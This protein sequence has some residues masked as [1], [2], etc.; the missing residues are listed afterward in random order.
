MTRKTLSVVVVGH[1]DH[2]KSTLIGRL[3]HDTGSLRADQVQAVKES[4]ARRGGHFEWAHLLDAFQAER[5]SAVTIDT[6]QAIL[7]MKGRDYYLID[8]P[9][10]REFL[11]SMVSGA[12]RADAAILVVDAA[13]GLCE[14]TMRHAYLLKLIGV[15][16]IIVA[17]TKMDAI[18]FD[19]TGF[20]SVAKNLTDYLAGLDLFASHVIPVSATDGI[21]VMHKGNAPGWYQGKTVMEAL[22]LLEGTAETDTAP[23]CFSVQD[24]Y[25]FDKKRVIA[26]RV[27]TGALNTGDAV[28]IL[29]SG[30]KTRIASIE[31]WPQPQ[32]SPAQS[33]QSIGLTLEDPVFI[34]RGYVLCNDVTILKVCNTISAHVVWLANDPLTSGDSCIIRIGS[35][36]FSAR[37]QSIDALIDLQNSTARNNADRISKND[38]ARVSLRVRGKAII[39]SHKN[40]AR[41]II[42]KDNI[43]CGAGM[44][45]VSACSAIG[46]AA[47]PKSHNIQSVSHT[48]TL[49]M[50]AARAG[51]AGGIFWLTGLPGAG[52]STLA[53]AVEQVLFER[54]INAYVLDGDNLRHGLNKDL[55]FSQEDRHENIRRAGEVA[56]LQ[57]D[58]GLVVLASFISPYQADRAAAR[59]A[60]PHLF[61]EIFIRADLATCEARDPK[62]HYKK[63]RTG[64]IADFTGI[65]AP[66]EVPSD[67]DLVI[68][69]QKCGIDQCVA[70][71]VDY[72][73]AQACLTPHHDK[74]FRS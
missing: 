71:I 54:R 69:T 35:Q 70:Q 46:Q 18:G 51:H 12:T 56:A 33:G 11:K 65:S 43:V 17:I 58:A 34:E 59:A 37:L 66:Y 44:I 72:I 8:A 7:T 29:P 62:G 39:G 30:E 28:T 2:G 36:E 61:H 49:Q 63:A 9:G 5:D 60:A 41:L 53:M 3:L 26:G 4:S 10:H 24:V 42:I 73:L 31:S 22:E 45:D 55:G 48:I 21:G 27:E 16:D 19:E 14:Q 50:R 38:T 52:K 23:L 74:T 40:L 68:D 67:P 6:A 25:L 47:A 64:E 1:V 57:A 32:A 15:R 20:K 13:E